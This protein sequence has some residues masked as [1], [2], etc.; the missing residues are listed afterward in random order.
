LITIPDLRIAV[1]RRFLQKLDHRPV[2]MTGVLACFLTALCLVLNHLPLWHT[3]I[4]AHLKFGQWI[5][6]NGRLPECEPFSAWSN[7]QPYVPMAWLS[8]VILSQVYDSGATLAMPSE[9]YEGVR[10]AG[11]DALRCLGAVL[12]ACRFLMLFGAYRRLSQSSI[13]GLLGI[14]FCLS[15]SLTH[16]DV[17]RP[18]VFGEFCLALMLFATC[19]P[20]PSKL[21]SWLVP[22][23]LAL[24]ANLHGSF[25]NG[26]L[27]LL[28]VMASRFFQELRESRG[29]DFK[30]L[31]HSPSMRRFFRMFYLSV[32]A[33][34]FLNPFW[35]FHW[36]AATW[37]FA[38]NPNVATMDEWQRLDWQSPSGWAFLGSLLVILGTH[39]LA[40]RRGTGGINFGHWLLILCFGLQVVFYQ[41]MLPW[42]AMLAPYVCMGPW[43]RLLDSVPLSP[44]PA[45]GKAWKSWALALIAVWVAFAW[46]TAG[47]LLLQH[48]AAPLERSLHPGTPRL[49]A[50]AAWRTPLITIPKELTAALKAN[51]GPIFCSETLGDY[52]LFTSAG[53]PIV[54]S[55]VQLFPA[56]HWQRC[57][58]VKEGKEGWQR[59][60]QSWNARILLVEVELHPQLCQQV[61]KDKEWLVL[62][63]EAGSTQKRDPKARHFLAVHR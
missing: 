35:S 4:W 26:L 2:L 29:V 21:A 1:F 11:V 32:F 56:E 52:L 54:Y 5:H 36:F 20:L 31:Y 61:R 51:H 41:R 30:T 48:Q 63:D 44:V 45:T 53:Q 33:V 9:P 8:Q 15:L 50:Q 24:W 42:W 23:L 43:K 25:L 38:G 60:L 47:S 16:I 55:H 7:T 46:S 40:R 18:Q 28:G 13:L 39:L 10:A 34:S 58:L 57:L 12:V 6:Q 14:L 49:L 59:V 19:K 17:L 22:L 62:L 3:D 27:M 37:E